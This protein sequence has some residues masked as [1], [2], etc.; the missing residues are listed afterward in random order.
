MFYHS[1]YIR[2]HFS[3]V[4]LSGT[5][6]YRGLMVQ[7]RSMAD[8][9]PVGSFTAESGVTRLSDCARSDVCFMYAVVVDVHPAEFHDT[10]Y[11]FS[12]L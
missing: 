4:T 5:V 11:S 6:Q 2:T 8:D 1:L 12:S 10:V 7:A 3:A 9:S